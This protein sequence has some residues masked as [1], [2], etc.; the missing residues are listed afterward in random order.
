M[1]TDLLGRLPVEV[2][3]V[4]TLKRH[5]ASLLGL[6]TY[7]FYRLNFGVTCRSWLRLLTARRS[8]FVVR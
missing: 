2:I 8:T 6:R 1:L 4:E 3:V 7:A 5:D